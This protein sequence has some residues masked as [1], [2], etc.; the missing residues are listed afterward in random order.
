MTIAEWILLI[1]GLTLGAILMRETRRL[2]R[3]SDERDQFRYQ[4]DM[5]LTAAKE[6]V[7]WVPWPSEDANALEKAIALAE[8][9]KESA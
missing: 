8:G 9:G 7:Q 5:L 1:C 6:A 3:L 4:R 2:N